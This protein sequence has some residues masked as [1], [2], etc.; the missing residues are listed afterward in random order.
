LVNKL[1]CLD[2]ANAEEGM[3]LCEEALKKISLIQIGEEAKK[4]Q[5]KFYTELA[6]KLRKPVLNS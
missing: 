5:N 2:V 6:Q 4:E 3:A 1:H